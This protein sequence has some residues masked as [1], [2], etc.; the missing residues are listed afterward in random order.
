MPIPLI[1]AGL[2]AAGAATGGPGAVLLGKGARDLKRAKQQSS[3]AAERYSS[4][5]TSFDKRVERT[6]HGLRAYG[7]LQEAARDDVVLRMGEFLRRHQRQVRESESLL[8]DGIHVSVGQVSGGTGLDVDAISWVRGIVGSTVA[9][10][11]AAVGVTAAAS[12]FGVAST[13]AAISGLS[14]AAAQSAT[15][16]FLG[17]GSLAAGGGGMAL[18]ATALNVVTAGPALLVSGLVVS[19][20]GQKALTQAK[21]IEVKVSKACAELD[22]QSA[23]L[24]GVDSRVTELRSLMTGLRTRALVALDELESEPFEPAIHAQRF[25]RAMILVMAVR[26]T[27]TTP[28]LTSDGDLSDE[29]AGLKI[30]YRSLR[31]ED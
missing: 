21:E 28:V 13:G 12:T 26:D 27:A 4:R 30:K 29:S 14:G 25:Q 2:I 5:R 16:A 24:D 9:G 1:A 15:L 3:M 10:S 7:K 23:R 6:N 18:G 8:V 20:N 17:G 19:G 22:E 31:E 11:G